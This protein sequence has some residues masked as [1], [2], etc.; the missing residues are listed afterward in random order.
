VRRLRTMETMFDYRRTGLGLGG[1]SDN[2]TTF[3][4]A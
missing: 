3:H 2:D 1:L 4:E